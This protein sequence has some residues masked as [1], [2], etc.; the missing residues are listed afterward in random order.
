MVASARRPRARRG[1]MASAMVGPWEV[2]DWLRVVN[3]VF[4]D[5]RIISNMGLMMFKHV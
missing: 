1:G 2:V 3:V 5:Q 4:N